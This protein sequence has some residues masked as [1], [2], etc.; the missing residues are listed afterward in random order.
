MKKVYNLQFAVLGA[1]LLIQHTVM[2]YHS[3]ACFFFLLLLSSET[4]EWWVQAGSHC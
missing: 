1:T 2:F 4:F 3:R